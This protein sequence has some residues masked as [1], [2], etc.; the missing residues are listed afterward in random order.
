MSAAD[1]R[2]SDVVTL[3]LAMAL[4]ALVGTIGT[5]FHLAGDRSGVI[6]MSVCAIVIT[7]VL[8][9]SLYTLVESFVPTNEQDDDA[10][11]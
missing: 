3:V 6:L 11:S 2:V 7:I 5:S 4:L 1:T 9:M 10:R 8:A